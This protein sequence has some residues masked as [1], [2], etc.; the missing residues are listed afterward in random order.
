MLVDPNIVETYSCGKEGFI[1]A[2]CEAIGIPRLIDSALESPAG[3]PPE[4]SYGVLAMM[5]MVNMCDDHHPLYRLNE[6]YKYKDLEGIFHQSVALDQI[7]D[8]RF[9]GFLDLF[10]KAGCQKIFAKASANA[11]ITYGVQIKNINFDTTSKVMWGSYETAEGILGSIQID[12]GHSKDKRQDKKQIKY[13]IG[14]ANGI[15]VDAI[16]LSGNKDDKTYNTDTLERLNDVLENLQV[17][18]SDFYYIADSALFSEKNLDMAADRS[19]K[20]I[21]RM[22]DNVLLAKDAIDEVV[23]H[24]DGLDT[25][26]IKDY[27]GQSYDYKVLEKTCDYKG[28]ALKIATY[29][30]TKYKT[31]KEKTIRKKVSKELDALDKLSK[32]L[33]K[34]AFACEEDSNL[35]IEKLK[36]KDL[37]NFK[38]HKIDFTIESKLKRRRGRPSLDPKADLVGYEYFL[39]LNSSQDEA[40]IHYEI[41][42]ECCF[43]L[44]SNDLVINGE[45]IL[46]EYKTQDSVEKKF[47]QLKSPQFVNSIYLESPERIEAFSYL[48]LICMLLLS[49]AEYVVRRGLCADQDQVVGPGQ[50]KMKKPTQRAIYDM[51]YSVRVRVIKHPNKPWERSYANNLDESLIKILNYLDIPLETFIK[52][53]S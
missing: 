14:C 12:F 46:K 24:L 17:E 16:V 25:I 44:C 7:N 50:V 3:R 36:L 11:L 40:F 33:S 15:V 51:F 6:Y 28:H 8:D 30:S 27:K 19:I 5:M 47:K 48:M 18:K 31:Q 52:G 49:T 20:L 21:T 29:Y 39:K 1:V 53:S 37:K 35:E 32:V 38:Y 23:T 4:I 13:G 9:G 26:T 41:Q 43:V 22:P 45:E 42:R 2:L 10:Y 34:R